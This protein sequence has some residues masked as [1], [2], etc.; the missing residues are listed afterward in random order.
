MEVLDPEFEIMF[1]K[2]YRKIVGD[3]IDFEKIIYSTILKII[4]VH[5]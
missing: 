5:C 1:I 4:L 3:S 2:Y